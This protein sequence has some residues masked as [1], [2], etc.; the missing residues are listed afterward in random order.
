[1]ITA[2]FLANGFE[3]CEAL[4]TVDLLRRAGMDI[5]MIS[6]NDDLSVESSHGVAVQAN[7]LF[8]EIQPMDYDILIM[9]GGKVGTINLEANETLK[10]AFRKHIE[11]GR[12][13]C[14][15]CAAP[16]I[17]GHMGLLKGK[18]YTCYPGFN[19]DGFEGEYQQSLI[20]QDGHII[21]GRGMGATID[22]A[23]A[24][25]ETSMGLE[26]RKQVEI[27]IQYE[28]SFLEY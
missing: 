7:R 23:L 26:A 12:L 5:D 18:K 2:I 27:G 1:M 16:S 14:A 21:T 17:L 9:P 4:I 3:T 28:H 19:E 25:V 13:A 11:Q 15:I 6:M 24:I 8:K 20:V 22:F 10:L